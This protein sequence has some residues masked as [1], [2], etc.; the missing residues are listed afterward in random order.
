MGFTSLPEYLMV[1]E[2]SEG[3]SLSGDEGE[4]NEVVELKLE[5][6]ELTWFCLICGLWSR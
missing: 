4:D 3:E 2:G 6:A 5:A 1:L